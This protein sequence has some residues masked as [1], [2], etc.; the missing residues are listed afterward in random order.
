MEEIPIDGEG[1]KV[2]L[3]V[4]GYEQAAG[5]DTWDANWLRGSAS[6]EMFRPSFA[7]FRGTCSVAWQTTELH[8]FHESLRT[9]LDDLTGVATLSTIEDQVE[10]SIRLD[11]GRG[12]ITGRIEAHAMASL[13]FEAAT[14][15]T[16][17]Q[18]TFSALRAVVSMYPLRG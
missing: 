17:L 12:T 5:G 6:V 8:A 4:G 18:Q 16:Y 15:Q 3:G 9:L 10:L 13:E 14:D 11:R 7:S 1:L 2:V